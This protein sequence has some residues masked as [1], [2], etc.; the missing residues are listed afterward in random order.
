LIIDVRSLARK[1]MV[2]IEFF[3][4]QRVVTNTHS[5]DMPI[6]AETRVNDALEY[7]RHQYPELRLDEG[8]F[9][10]TVNQKKASLERVLRANETVSFLP[11][12]SGG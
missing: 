4:M 2:L 1:M 9:L 11:F 7:V 10:V 3:G 12:I 6:T 5:I 8:M